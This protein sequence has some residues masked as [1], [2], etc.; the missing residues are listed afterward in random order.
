MFRRKF[1]TESLSL[2]SYGHRFLD[3]LVFV[4][5]DKEKL[6][7]LLSAT[8]QTL[9]PLPEIPVDFK[10]ISEQITDLESV[11]AMKAKKAHVNLMVGKYLF[12]DDYIYLAAKAYQDEGF[13]N[14]KSFKQDFERFTTDELSVSKKNITPSKNIHHVFE[15]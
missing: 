15:M 12:A 2:K 4:K 8:I 13:G 14:I 10:N 6:F 7:K 11:A 9:N 3:L 1:M 5:N